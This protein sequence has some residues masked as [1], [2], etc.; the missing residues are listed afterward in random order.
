M[1]G[2]VEDAGLIIIGA[3][4]IWDNGTETRDTY[5]PV[6]LT[7]TFKSR[8][9][10]EAYVR[11]VPDVGRTIPNEGIRV[12]DWIQPNALISAKQFRRGRGDIYHITIRC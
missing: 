1:I 8:R 7:Q 4:W 2:S 5:Y 3:R 11:Y 6:D 12:E 10:K 9:L